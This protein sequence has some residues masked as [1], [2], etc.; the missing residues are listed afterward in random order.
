MTPP[1]DPRAEAPPCRVAVIGGGVIGRLH[2]GWLRGMPGCELVGLADPAPEAQ[3]FA[4]AEG[5][6]WYPDYRALLDARPDGVIVATP[7]HL[8][9][10]MGLDCIARGLPTLME[11]PVADTLEAARELTRAAETAGVPILVGHYRR[12][13]PIVQEARRIVASGR[14]GRIVAVSMRLVFTK[15]EAYFAPDWRRAEGG[16]PILI[17][18]IHDIDQL[19][20]LCGEI[21]SVQAATS[22]ATRG[23][24]VEDSAAII[25][26]LKSG[27]IATAIL[28]DTVAS[29][30]SWD[31]NAAEMPLYPVYG[32]DAYL[33]GGTD[34]SLTLPTLDLWSYRAAKGWQEP[35]H[36][37]VIAPHRE[38]PY[39]RQAAHFLRV[40]R[41]EERPA[42]SAEDGTRTL[43]VAAAIA[44]A[45]RSGQRVML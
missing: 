26:T 33:I 45:A 15:P 16:G 41:R 6:P 31:I 19:R 42:V 38:D 5:I 32:K 29:P 3:S 7:N 36:R 1:A 14:L 21:E 25:L 11:K 22:N 12:H 40:V 35:L 2:V 18:F 28:S 4:A 30:Y 20:F 23:F 39:L 10:S 24:A 34:G 13:N 37:E 27:A 43:A 8:H 9:L 44:A 17:N